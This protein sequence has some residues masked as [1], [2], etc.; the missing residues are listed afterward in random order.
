MDHGDSLISSLE[1]S[2]CKISGTFRIFEKFNLELKLWRK[3]CWWLQLRCHECKRGN[4]T[5]TSRWCHSL[6]SIAYFAF[7][8]TAQILMTYNSSNCQQ[9]KLLMASDYGWEF[10]Q[11]L[12]FS[13]M[14]LTTATCSDNCQVYWARVPTEFRPTSYK[15][16]FMWTNQNVSS[17]PWAAWM[18]LQCNAEIPHYTKSLILLFCISLF[19]GP[20][21]MRIPVV[22]SKYNRAS[23]WFITNGVKAFWSCAWTLSMNGYGFQRWESSKGMWNDN[24]LSFCL[25]V[26]WPLLTIFQAHLDTS[27]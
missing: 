25:S 22:N 10:W 23:N 14:W 15:K 8:P 5:C 19:Y 18:R 4:A 2:P 9:I 13:Q 24:F 21:V 11:W 3:M 16:W 1:S 7:L 27:V 12:F 6:L 20:C 26:W 17:L